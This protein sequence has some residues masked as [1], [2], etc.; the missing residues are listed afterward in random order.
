MPIWLHIILAVAVVAYFLFRY[1]K[2]RYFYELL[3]VIWAPLTLL[4]YVSR[5][6][7]F[8]RCLGIVQVLMFI[9]VIFFMF[10]KRGARRVKTM[11]MLSKMAADNLPT[12]DKQ[13][14]DDE[15]VDDFADFK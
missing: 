8:I 4:T 11:E 10:R 2:D 9:L 14:D 13:D 7:V 15:P 6:V 5:D 12:Q 3:F 1:I